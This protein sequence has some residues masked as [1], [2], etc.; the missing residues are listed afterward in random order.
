MNQKLAYKIFNKKF[1]RVLLLHENELTASSIGD[2]IA[3]I[4][5]Q[6]WK[7]IFIEKIDVNSTT[8]TCSLERGR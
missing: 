3:R 6:S 8:N 1:K 2:F 5:K 7:I 4:G